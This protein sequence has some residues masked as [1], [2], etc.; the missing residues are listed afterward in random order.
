MNSNILIK[1]NFFDNIDDIRK[2]ALTTSFNPF[3]TMTQR[4]GWRGYRTHELKVFG[5]RT[6]NQAN[7]KIFDTVKKHFNLN[8]DYE[9]YCYYHLSVVDTKN[10]LEDY[11]TNIFHKDDCKYAGVVY[12]YPDP[13]EN[14]GTTLIIDEASHSIENKYNRLISYD[15]KITH[16]PTDLFGY[17]IESGRLTITFYIE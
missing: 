1:D 10:T 11:E 13:P 12:L 2:I 5:N 8:D 14:T 4:V 3:E 15:A 7:E 16:A 17:N 9:I 6:I